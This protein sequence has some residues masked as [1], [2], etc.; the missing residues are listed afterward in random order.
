[1]VFGN[2]NCYPIKAKDK[3]DMS[4]EK[5]KSMKRTLVA[6][7]INQ[8]SSGLTLIELM[9]TLAV[10][11]I[12]VGIAYPS[13]QSIAINNNLKTATRDLASD[14]A[15]LKERAIGEYRMY[16]LTVDVNNNNYSLQQCGNQGANCNGWNAPFAVKNL[17]NIA[18]DIIFDAGGTNQTDFRFQTRGTMTPA[19]TVQLRNRRNSTAAITINITGRSNVQ[20]NLQ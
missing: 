14:F 16:R 9:I 11:A 17:S 10:L 8:P 3:T 6:K 12:V 2:E 7:G 18:A 5:K 19:G 4:A 15:S 13:F 20:F 1:M